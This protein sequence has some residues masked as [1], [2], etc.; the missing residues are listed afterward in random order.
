MRWHHYYIILTSDWF[1]LISVVDLKVPVQWNTAD[2]CRDLTKSSSNKIEE[3]FLSNIRHF[4]INF[5]RAEI[6][7]GNSSASKTSRIPSMR[8]YQPMSYVEHLLDQFW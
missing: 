5:L 7:A 3:V 1:L 4:S 2:I 6:T 8:F